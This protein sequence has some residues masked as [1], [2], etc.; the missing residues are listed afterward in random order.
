MGTLNCNYLKDW[1][2]YEYQ[3]PLDYKKD[4]GIFYTDSFLVKK[5]F[6]ELKLPKSKS[7]LDPCCGAGSF[8]FTAL[9]KGYTNVYGADIDENS[10]KLFQK[11]ALDSNMIQYDT[12]S[13]SSKDVFMAFGV[14]KFDCI[15]GNPPYAAL[16]PNINI[17]TSR[18]FLQTVTK[19]G[20]NLFIAALIRSFQLC[21]KS[22]IIAYIIP[23][24]FLH[25]KSY[26]ALRK[27]ILKK[28]T[29]LEIIDIGQYF[30]DVRG[31]QIILIL[32]NSGPQN[33]NIVFKSLIKNQFVSINEINQNF[34]DNEIILFNSHIEK[35]IYLK[36]KKSFCVLGD[37]CKGY[38]GRG[39]STDIQS[40]TGKNIRK[41][42][43]KDKS[44]PKYGDQIFIQNIYSS[45]SGIIAAF[46]G[47][48]SAKETVT[49]LTD[50]SKEMCKYLLGIL[51]SKVCNFYLQKFCYNNS[52]L[53][54][55]TDAKYLLEIPLN[56]KNKKTFEKVINIVEKIEVL[57][58]L[59]TEW[60]DLIDV[61]DALVYEIYDLSS[62]QINYIE[63]S[64][65]KRLSTRW[66]KNGK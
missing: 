64:M 7:I 33:N 37:I 49:I 62:N 24:N 63:T 58:Y 17:K 15:L 14:N 65:K 32:Q 12:I 51:H 4:F 9:E 27:Y 43:Y 41:F 55:H 35:D 6:D 50:S 11:Y 46:G 54:M 44:I 13:N 2:A 8:L 1:K 5:I 59:S 45:E 57:E 26:S 60:Y 22:G 56:I 29:I 23:K 47:K 19:S 25:V 61:L 20:N 18:E 38:I 48:M 10:I 30:S 36:L 39:R 16:K 53:T 40:I 21:K 34:Y 52:T 3:L 31:E 42:G 66:Y 28:K